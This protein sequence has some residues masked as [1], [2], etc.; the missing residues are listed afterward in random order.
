MQEVTVVLGTFILEM[1][2][3]LLELLPVPLISRLLHTDAFMEEIALAPGKELA[4]LASSALWD[5]LS[6]V[7]TMLIFMREPTLLPIA[8]TLNVKFT[9]SS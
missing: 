7:L 8:P 3:L 4:L 6:M 9:W 1:A 2:L 5:P